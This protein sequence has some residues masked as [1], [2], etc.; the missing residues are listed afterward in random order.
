MT[1]ILMAVAL[2]LVIEGLLYAVMPDTMKRFLVQM[3][4]IPS[5]SLRQAGLV[6]AVLGVV[7]AYVIRG[8]G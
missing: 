5:G 1:D 6:A 2:I 7:L 8:L 3:L 4:D